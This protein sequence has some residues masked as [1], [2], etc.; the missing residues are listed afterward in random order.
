MAND[1]EN[2]LRLFMADLQELLWRH[3]AELSVNVAVRQWP[4]CDAVLKVN[5]NYG[6]SVE[7]PTSIEGKEPAP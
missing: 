7:L 6:D 3:D 5:W 1:K 2:R 4:L